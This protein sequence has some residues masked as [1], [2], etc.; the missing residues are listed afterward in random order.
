MREHLEFERTDEPG[1]KVGETEILDAGA[2]GVDT[3]RLGQLTPQ[4]VEVESVGILGSLK[5]DVDPLSRIG[6][7]SVPKEGDQANGDDDKRRHKKTPSRT[8]H[9]ISRPPLW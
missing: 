2:I 7:L 1:G 3:S 9:V 8:G 5:L 4:P 6:A